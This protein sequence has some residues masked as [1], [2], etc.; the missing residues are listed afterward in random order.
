MFGCWLESCNYRE[1][2]S[3]ERNAPNN[4]QLYNDIYDNYQ[5]QCSSQRFAFTCVDKYLW[6]RYKS[7]PPGCLERRC[8]T[9]SC[10]DS[11]NSN[12]V[13]MASCE[14][15]GRATLLSGKRSRF[16]ARIGSKRVGSIRNLLV[17]SKGFI[18]FAVLN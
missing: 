16:V 13:R 3:K 12:L 15:S 1:D 7:E 17:K 18:S 11:A 6:S 14:V 10:T 9:S 8:T 5:L 4:N 2:K